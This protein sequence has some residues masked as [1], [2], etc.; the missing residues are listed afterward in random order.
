[1][2]RLM[3]YLF[4]SCRREIL[5]VVGLGVLGGCSSA[6]IIAIVNAVFHGSITG[7]LVPAGFALAVILKVSA[8]LLSNVVLLHLTQNCIL[9]LCDEICSQV[10]AA[11]LRRIEEAGA[12][13]CWP[14]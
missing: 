14:R 10:V 11:P 2:I 9:R 7:A 6:A 4:R 5:L 13:A 3:R 1:M 12:R 8:G